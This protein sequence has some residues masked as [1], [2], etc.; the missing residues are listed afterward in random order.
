MTLLYACS[1]TALTQG[2][3]VGVSV[4]FRVVPWFV[5]GWGGVG[6]V[7]RVFRG[8]VIGMILAGFGGLKGIFKLVECLT[9]CVN[10]YG[11]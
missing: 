5:K 7:F 11:T 3:G 8:L 10:V 2:E 9:I 4:L 1:V 6:G